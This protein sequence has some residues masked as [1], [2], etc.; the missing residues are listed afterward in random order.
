MTSPALLVEP[1]DDRRLIAVLAVAD[2]ARA[3]DGVDPFNEQTRLDLASSRRQAHLGSVGGDDVVVAVTGGGELDLVVTPAARARGYGKAML[4]ALLP[5]L[6]AEVS[7]WSHGDHPAAR[8]LAASHGF[9]R[10]RV[11]LRLAL[12]TLPGA[13]PRTAAREADDGIR[14]TA[15][16]PVTDAADW[17]ALN[18]RAFA[19]H[20]E[21][22]RVTAADL[23]EREAEDWFDPEDFLVARDAT[24]RM[25]GFHW[26]KLE[27]GSDDG[28]VYVLG[29]H[30]DAAGH[31][32]GGRLLAAGL[33]HLR[34]RGRKTASLYVEGDNVPAL[35]LYRRAGFV[36][37]IVDVQYR[38]SR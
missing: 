24:G 35:A 18:A 4:T 7:A 31:G 28:E 2:A 37:D 13:V 12:P 27:P 5:G 23:V 10:V 33:T 20:P 32:L 6:D 9:D 26:L 36:D 25:V 14:L 38:R 15:F 16:D 3:A 1:A 34:E 29:V 22:G 19:T 21:Q 11:L 17:L 30:P 8:A